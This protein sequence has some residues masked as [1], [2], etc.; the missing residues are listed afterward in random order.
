MSI[1]S[2]LQPQDPLEGASTPKSRMRVTVLTILALHVVFIGGLL[3]QGCDKKSGTNSAQ[4]PASTGS[5]PSLGDTNSYFSNFPGDTPG[6]AS[7][8][9]GTGNAGASG[10]GTIGSAIPPVGSPSVA[11]G[12]GAGSLGTPDSGTGPTTSTGLSSPSSS[13]GGVG[14]STH[15]TGLPVATS[16]TEPVTG[17]SGTEHVIKQGDQL[18]TIARRYGVTVQAI[19]DANPTVKP[20]NLKVNDKLVIPPPAPT[21]AAGTATAV[22]SASGATAGGAGAGGTEG[23]VYIVKQGDNLTRIGKKFG[24]S[25]KALRAANHLKNDRLVPKQRLVI[26]AKPAAASTAPS[27]R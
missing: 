17:G 21:P 3:M 14:T 8:G 9:T 11:Q 16:P 1:P 22:A 25:P 12:A 23:E 2:P 18:S 6:V 20:R 13:G 26:P 4:N 10:G 5:L 27:S 19:V 24:V 7:G 15:V